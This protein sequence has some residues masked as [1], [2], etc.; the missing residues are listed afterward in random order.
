MSMTHLLYHL[1]NSRGP[2]PSE[3]PRFHKQRLRLHGGSSQTAPS[4]L[5]W[6]LSSYMET[7]IVLS[8]VQ[9]VEDSFS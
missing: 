3:V 8:E 7:E 4:V 2:V 5:F 1:Y 9:M 6:D